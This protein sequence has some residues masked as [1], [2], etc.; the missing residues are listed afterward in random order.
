MLLTM[1]NS[2]QNVSFSARVGMA[3]R[4]LFNAEF[5]RQVVAGLAAQSSERPKAVASKAPVQE[6]P[7][8]RVNASGLFVLSAL[9]REGRLIDFLQQEVTG[10]SDEE[11]GAAARVVHAGCSKI[12]KQYFD[13]APALAGEEGSSTVIP[14]GFDPERIRLTGNVTGQPPYK[15][16]LKHHGWVAKEI[17]LPARQ[18]SLDPRMVAPAEVELA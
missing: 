11:V 10:F 8:E 5:A 9:Q 3:F 15:G 18:E 1:E 4:L 6:L 12:L 7:P 2:E 16:T 17:R 14:Q 13:F